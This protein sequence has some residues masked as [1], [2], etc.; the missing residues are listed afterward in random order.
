MNRKALFAVI[1]AVVALAGWG[2][3]RLARRGQTGAHAHAHAER[4]YCPM[5]PEVVQDRPGTCPICNMSLVLDESAHEEG[6][7]QAQAA[8]WTCP[9]HPEI[10]KDG[11]GTCPICNMTLVKKEASETDV[12]EGTGG[13]AV[14]RLTDER[15]RLIGLRSEAVES[16]PLERIVR[17]SGRV[18][19]DPDLYNAVAEYREAVRARKEL[20]GSV[21]AE[22]EERSKALVAASAIKL[23]QMGL[24]EDLIKEAGEGADPTTLLVGGKTVWVYAQI[25]EQE[26]GLVKPGQK[27]ALTSPAFSGRKFSGTVRSLDPILDPATRSLKV[28]VEVPNPDKA[29]K[30]EMYVDAE[31]RV[32]LGTKPALPES[33]LLDTGER[34]LVFVDLGEGRLEPRPVKVGPRAG[35]YY[36]ILDG[37][38]VGE[39]VVIAANFLL[40]S[41]SRLKGAVGKPAADPHAGHGR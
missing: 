30:L 16:R 15:R 38:E 26:V 34:R 6:E 39:K 36:E 18:A 5:H 32:A 2:G 27:V 17:A 40:D 23:R 29:L 31:I 21:L 12:A 11:P 35:A 4:W 19:Y 28:R 22:A 14:V 24:G 8:L 13:R 25:Y 20:S 9:M 37:V 41:E 33:S 7:H 3:L 10:V 1:V